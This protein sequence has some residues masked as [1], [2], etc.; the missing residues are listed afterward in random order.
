MDPVHSSKSHL[1]AKRGTPTVG[2]LR[3]TERNVWIFVGLL[4]SE[5]AAE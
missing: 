5:T 1:T 4:N 3:A 2:A